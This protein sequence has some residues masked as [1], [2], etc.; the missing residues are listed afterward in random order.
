[1]KIIGNILWFLIVGIMSALLWWLT[2]LLFC[3]TLIGI[4][5]GLQCFKIGAACLMPI[6]KNIVTNFEAHPIANVLW[7]ILFGWE[8]AIGY[9]AA[10]IVLCITLVGIPF[11]VQC[12]KLMK[13]ALLPFGACIE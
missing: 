4:P 6:G 5:F 9:F 12:F 10:G 3:I 1:M 11:A 2:G 13:L 8:I 7:L